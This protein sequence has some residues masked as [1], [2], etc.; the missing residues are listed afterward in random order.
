MTP[1]E[2]I[3]ATLGLSCELGRTVADIFYQNSALVLNKV[4][5][6]GRLTKFPDSR[7]PL[8][9]DVPVLPAAPNTRT[10]CFEAIDILR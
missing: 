5:E 7:R 8:M 3:E 1:L 2:R 6:L 4:N 9:I 10:D